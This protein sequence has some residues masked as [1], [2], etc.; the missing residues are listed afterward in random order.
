MDKKSRKHITIWLLSACTIIF[1]MVVIGGV[2]RLTKSGL[3]MVE[4]HPI[5]GMLPPITD[6]DWQ[7]E[8]SK[9]KNFPESIIGIISGSFSLGLMLAG[10]MVSKILDKFGLYKTMSIAISMQAICVIIAFSKKDQIASK[11]N[12]GNTLH[13]TAK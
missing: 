8:F 7:L 9:Y 2:T 11:I 3:S 5:T 10:F 12:A 1:I 13:I 6:N 4:W